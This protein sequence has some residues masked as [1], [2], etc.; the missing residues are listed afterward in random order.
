M[1]SYNII[2]LNQHFPTYSALNYIH[3]CRLKLGVEEGTKPIFLSEIYKIIFCFLDL[4][5][6]K[7]L[8]Q[9]NL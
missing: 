9:L 3:P 4:H 8:K 7:Q 2:Y 1:Q 6:F 5:H